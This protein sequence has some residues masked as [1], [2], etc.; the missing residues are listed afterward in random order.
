[1]RNII[2]KLKW[3]AW[4]NK[5]IKLNKFKNFYKLIIKLKGLIMCMHKYNATKIINE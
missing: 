1:L 2:T 3:N 4:F 5:T